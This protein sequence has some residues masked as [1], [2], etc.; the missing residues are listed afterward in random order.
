[1]ISVTRF[2]LIRKGSELIVTGMEDLPCP[3]C[4]GKLYVHGTCKRKLKTVTGE[5]DTLR[6]RVMECT[7]CGHTHRELIEGIVPY[8][9][10]S[11]DLICAIC[12]PS[13]AS[14]AEPCITDESLAEDPKAYDTYICEDSVRSRIISWISWFIAYMREI[15]LYQGQ[16]WPDQHSS[17]SILLKKGVRAIVNSGR[18]KIQHQ[19]VMQP[20]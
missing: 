14:V 19:I 4:S 3:D 18:W 2:T 15:D 5:T 11:I 20:S 7:M 16:H 9:Q 1:M 6:L 13:D 17:L 8:R 10:Y 12:E